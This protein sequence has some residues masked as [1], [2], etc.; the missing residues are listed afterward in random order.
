VESAQK[1]IA[2]IF[3]GQGSQH[4]GMGQEIAG[5][6]PIAKA[7][8]DEAGEILGCDLARLCFE[9]PVEQLNRTEYT[10]PALLVTS[11][12]LY[13]VLMG[14]PFPVAMVAGHSLG[15]YSA[16]A[17][18]GGLKLADAAILVRQRGRYM[19][20]AVPDGT[21]LMAAI[22]GLNREEVRAVCQ[23]AADHGVVSEANYN[24]PGQIVISGEKSAVQAAIESAKKKG[25]KK[26]IPLP[27]S[28]PSHCALMEPAS[29]RLKQDL[30]R[31]AIADLRIPLVTNVEAVAVGS[32]DA[33]RKAL[34]RQLAQPVLWEDSIQSMI[35]A[36]I[37][38]F[39]EVGPGRVLSGLVKRIHRE[40]Q[41]YN[42]EDSRSLKE[43]LDGL[44]LA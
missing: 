17:A 44:N 28:V 38:V 15:E 6:Y 26:V 5:G 34:I 30:D 25:A 39:I 1:K 31:T 21:G 32:S 40:S 33:I 37:E 4:V 42:V 19:Q 41:V 43:T 9:G 27:V 10:Q 14:V 36:G 24:S 23:E 3:P 16:I 12:A 20:E 29:R 18:A 35:A 8:F 22:L 2:L 7:V 13:R 11:I